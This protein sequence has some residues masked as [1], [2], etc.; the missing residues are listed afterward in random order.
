M[1]KNIII[2]LV[3]LLGVVVGIVIAMFINIYG[4]KIVNIERGM[5]GEM[6]ETQ[7]LCFKNCYYVEYE[8]EIQQ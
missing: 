8:D 3:G 2:V 1:K 5:D 6:V 7:V 4:L